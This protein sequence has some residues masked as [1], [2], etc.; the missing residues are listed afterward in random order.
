MICHKKKIIF[1]HIPKCAGSSVKNF[2]FGG[3]SLKWNVPNYDVLYGWCPKRKIHM[4]HATTKQL[5]ETNLISEEDWNDYFKFTI[6][7]N[8]WDRAYSDY[9]WIMKNS[10]IQGS[11]KNYIQK[12]GSFREILS[13]QN[14]MMY[15]GD[16]LIPQTDFFSFEGISKLDFVC[17]FETLMADLEVI[18]HKL[19]VDERMNVFEKKNFKRTSHYSLF[20][21]NTRR[22][23]VASKFDNDINTLKY[24][25]LDC[26]KGVLKFKNFI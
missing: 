9:M 11:F 10:K 24:H 7:R 1:I 21:T 22:K 5:L 25:F 17:R 3:H 8:P 23:L 13:N 18:K 15:R 14:T 16:H 20:Y 2:Y 6:V 4:Q 26:K 12:S 19:G